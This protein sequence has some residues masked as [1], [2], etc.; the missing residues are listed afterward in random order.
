MQSVVVNN[1]VFLIGGSENGFSSTKHILSIRVKNGRPAGVWLASTP[2]ATPLSDCGAC[3]VYDNLVV[4]GGEDQCPCAFV[5]DRSSSTWLKLPEL[6][7]G[8]EVPV[9][10]HF[11]E[12]LLAVSGCVV[13][14][15]YKN[16]VEELSLPTL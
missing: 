4:A 10:V 8:R 6:N 5:F 7:I 11:G 2:P 1:H 9:L 15:L 13:G 12:S 14:V 3:Y 16:T